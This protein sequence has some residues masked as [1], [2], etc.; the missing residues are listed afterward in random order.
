MG[1]GGGVPFGHVD[2]GGRRGR[3]CL[4]RRQL[5]ATHFL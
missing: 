3:C 2:S 1:Q 4:Q 5:I